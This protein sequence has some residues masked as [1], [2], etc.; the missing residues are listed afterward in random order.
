M[1]L[2]GTILNGAIAAETWHLPNV[3][4]QP[5]NALKSQ[6]PLPSSSY[7]TNQSY[8][9]NYMHDHSMATST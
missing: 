3:T 2:A 8:Y 9:S 7:H 6:L 4:F 1:Q 5:A